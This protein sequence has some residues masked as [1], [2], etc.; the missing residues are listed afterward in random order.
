MDCS[1]IPAVNM[2]LISKRHKWR[3]CCSSNDIMGCSRAS[4]MGSSRTL[5]STYLIEVKDYLLYSIFCLL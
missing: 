5:S 1:I 2:N 3:Y 4:A